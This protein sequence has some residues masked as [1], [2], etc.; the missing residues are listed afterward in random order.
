MTEATQAAVQPAQPQALTVAQAAQKFAEQRASAQEQGQQGN[1]V[2]DAARMLG[3]R[4]AQARQ[5]RQAQAAQ[6]TGESS[7]EEGG[8]VE[9]DSATEAAETLNAETDQTGQPGETETQAEAQGE[10]EAEQPQMIDLGD[11]LTVTLDEVR[12]GFML[13]ADHTRKTQAVAEKSK[14][15][16][17]KLEQ[18]DKIIGA[19][20]AKAGQPK[21]LS[22]LMQ[23]YGRDE[24]LDRYAAQE[25]EQKRIRAAEGVAQ[26]QRN[27]ILNTKI[28]ERDEVLAQTYN[29]EW[30]DPA[31]RDAA[32]TELSEY[33]L[34]RGATSEM[35]RAM[36]EPWMIEILDESRQLRALKSKGAEV[37]KIVAAKPKV[38][39][40][41]AKV[42]AQAG[43]FSNVQRARDTLKK[44]GSLADA[45]A[46]LRAQRGTRPG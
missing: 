34:K 6:Q 46:L 11:G 22:E 42:S 43:A 31:K 4:A 39:K 36:T 23:E 25:D 24:G 18:L 29:K 19:L 9:D 14:A 41:G 13:K 12:D 45:V 8:T 16:D 15:V 1:Q 7:Q 20:R 40:P 32:Y 30:A 26:R 28:R 37:K 44:S 3:Q 27:D 10:S 38:I 21:T 2:S 17:Q 33:A 35:I 5:E